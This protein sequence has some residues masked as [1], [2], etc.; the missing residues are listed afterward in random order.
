MILITRGRESGIVRAPME[1]AREALAEPDAE[2]LHRW[3]SRFDHRAAGRGLG[4]EPWYLDGAVPADAP[5]AVREAFADAVLAIL[6]ELVPADGFVHMA[7]VQHEY[8]RVYPHRVSG[9]PFDDLCIDGETTAHVA[10]DRSWGLVS[11]GWVS[12]MVLCCF[13]EALVARLRER[14]PALLQRLVPLAE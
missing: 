13:G 11:F 14:A 4:L 3:V 12:P 8:L 9:L 2:A 10:L 1:P 6:R 5:A 7:D